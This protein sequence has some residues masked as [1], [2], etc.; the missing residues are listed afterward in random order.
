MPGGCLPKGCLP[1]WGVCPVGGVSA[2][3]EGVS[4]HGGCLLRRGV[5]PL[6]YRILDTRL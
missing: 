4:A 1:R 2:H 6:V 5:H 3:E